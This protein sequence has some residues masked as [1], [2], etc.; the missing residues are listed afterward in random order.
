MEIFAVSSLEKIFADKKP[1]CN[2]LKAF[3]MLKNERSS[4]QIVFNIDKK[5]DISVSLSG[6]CAQF[7]NKFIVRDVP[8]GLAA[9]DNVDDFFISK[10]SGL[11]PDH[12]E[13]LEKS[14]AS[15]P[16][17]WQ[18][19]WLEI[20]PDGKYSGKG[21]LSISLTDADGEVSSASVEVEVINADLPEQE[22]V[23]TNWYHADCLCNYYNIEPFSDEF[24]R[25]N[26]SF[27]STAVRHGVNCILTPLFTPPLDTAVGGERTTVQLVGVKIRGGS[28][29]FDFR[30]LSKWIDLCLEC[31]VKYFEMSHFFTQW[32]AKHA[33]KIAAVDRKGRTKKIFGWFT[34]TS[35]KKYDDFL[36]EFGKKLIPFLEKKGIS[37]RCYFHISDEPSDRHLKTYKKR[38]TLIAEIFPGFPVIDALSDIEFYE[39]GITKCPIPCENDIEPFVGMVPELWVYYCCGQC[40]ENVPN[41]FIAMPSVRNRILGM[42]MY[43]YDI[44]GFLQWG[45]NFYN[46][47][48]S[49]RQIN[50]YE[51]TDAG[52]AFPSG[53]SFVVYP[54]KDGTALPSLRFKVFY[55]GFQD[56]MALKLLESIIG[57]EKALD[58]IGEKL[59]FKEYPQ[60]PAWLLETREKINKAIKENI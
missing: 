15:V 25:I 40:R 3:S 34:R 22:L 17:K 6:D 46:S 14:F 56:M 12:L 28:Y 42:I 19:I 7:V 24:W 49:L 39:K 21:S 10:E 16:G 41:R 47:Q 30:N 13:P 35:S 54:A 45:Y 48:Y 27:I 31:G 44:K 29:T 18:S 53:D 26:R 51:I 55:D 37:D 11:Y 33:P 36:R 58:V 60:D 4:F 1:V 8:V 57:R 38:S 52:H 5:T 59:S 20:E 43:E 9:F 32:G 50:P 2:E 23:H